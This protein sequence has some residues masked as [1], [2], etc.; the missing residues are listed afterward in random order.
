MAAV[1][2]QVKV[3]G[4]APDQLPAGGKEAVMAY[5]FPFNQ[6]FPQADRSFFLA[7]IA[8]TLPCPEKVSIPFSLAAGVVRATPAPLDPVPVTPEIRAGRLKSLSRRAM[9]AQGTDESFTY[10][11]MVRPG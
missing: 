9:R 7:R 1:A 6:A 3:F 8:E 11:G 5:V 2:R 4:D 10:S